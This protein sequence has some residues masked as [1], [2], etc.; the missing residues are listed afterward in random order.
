MLKIGKVNSIIRLR[1]NSDGEGVRSV[2]FLQNC[3]LSCVWCCN[4]ET[5]C[6]N[7]YKEV[8]VEQLYDLIARDQIYFDAT[9]GGITFSGGEPFA[10]IEFVKDFLIKYSDLFTCNIETSLYTSFEHIES[11][12]PFINEWYIDFKLF[13][14][15]KHIEYTGVSNQIIKQNLKFLASKIDTAKII[16]AFPI[17]TGI[18][19]SVENVEN[20]INFMKSVKL[21]RVEFHP[22]RKN[23]EKKNQKLGL[24]YEAIDPLSP[25]IL[26]RITDQFERNNIEIVKHDTQ[27]ERAKCNVLKS[28]RREFCKTNSIPLAIE[29]CTYNGRCVGTCPKCEDELGYINKWRENINA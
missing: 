6:G 18:N 20:M 24:E 26:L 13:D 16:V 22:Y 14:E 5:R 25:A 29:E 2:V 1:I 8:N 9:G 27:V 12:I 3:P 11:I 28:I 15:S 17:I 21:H 4:P 23:R 10:Q 19:D 7:K